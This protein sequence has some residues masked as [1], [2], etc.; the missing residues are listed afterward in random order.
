LP[1]I[2]QQG[3]SVAAVLASMEPNINANATGQVCLFHLQQHLMNIK[4]S[5]LGF[6]RFKIKVLFLC[7]AYNHELLLFKNSMEVYIFLTAF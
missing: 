3:T 2:Q 4:N 7:H 5:K 1:A 6:F